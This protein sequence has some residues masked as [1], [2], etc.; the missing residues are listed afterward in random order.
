MISSTLG[1]FLINF[2]KLNLANINFFGILVTIKLESH[3]LMHT[4]QIPHYWATP[5]DLSKY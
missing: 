3:N 1:I 4:T 5:S 2:I